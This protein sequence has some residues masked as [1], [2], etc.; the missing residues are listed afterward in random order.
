MDTRL[1]E[2]HKSGNLFYHA[3]FSDVLSSIKEQG[4][5]ASGIKTWPRVSASGFVYITS[6]PSAS[7]LIGNPTACPNYDMAAWFNTL[8][9]MATLSTKYPNVLGIDIFNEPYGLSW[10]QWQ[11]SSSEAARKILSINPRILIFVEG[12]ANKETDNGGKNAFWGENLVEAGAN[13]PN[14]PLARLV[15]SPHVYGPSVAW[16]EYFSDPTFPSNMDAIWEAHF[17]YLVQKGFTL[18]VGEFGGRYTDK[19]RIWQNAFVE[20]LLK[21]NMHNTYYWSW[22]PNSGDTGGILYDDW[23]TVNQDKMNLLRKLF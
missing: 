4:I 2:L 10:K 11:V 13:L 19:D 8:E 21:K 7:G 16:Q 9:K 6:M 18:V 3:T 15:L 22:N 14:I 1:I 12:V 17:G 5:T 23:N 20:Y